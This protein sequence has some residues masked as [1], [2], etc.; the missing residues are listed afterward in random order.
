MACFGT[1]TEYV[2]Y[3]LETLLQEMCI[4]EEDVRKSVR[5]RPSIYALID[6]TE[7]RQTE[8]SLGGDLR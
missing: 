1:G 2:G 5:V 6:V 7:T 3:S 4:S 8:Q